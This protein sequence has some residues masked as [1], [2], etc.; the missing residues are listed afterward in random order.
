MGNYVHFISIAMIFIRNVCLQYLCKRLS[1]FKQ[2]IKI[3]HIITYLSGFLYV[4][5]K[6]YLV[7]I[8]KETELKNI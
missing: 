8:D 6:K 2:L 4:N 5:T 1:Y 3:T 7:D